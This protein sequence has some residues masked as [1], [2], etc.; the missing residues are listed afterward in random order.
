MKSKKIFISCVILTLIIV[1][2]AIVY[3]SSNI[4]KSQKILPEEKIAN[5][6]NSYEKITNIDKFDKNL[7]I[8]KVNEYNALINN[9]VTKN[10][11][12]IKEEKTNFYNNEID[13]RIETVINTG[14]EVY[15][16][17]A[18]SG[19][20]IYYIKNST[21]SAS[22]VASV[23]LTEEEI[24]EIGFELFDT[25]KGE[26]YKD[27]VFTS[28]EQYDEELWTIRFHKCYDGLV[29]SGEAVKI[30]FS[31][32][33]KQIENLVI[34]DYP[35]TNNEIEISEEEA[36]KTAKEYMKKYTSATDMKMEIMIVKP[37]YFWYKNLG[38]YKSVNFRRKAYVFTCN[39][40][41]NT[42]IYV[43]CTTGEV[44]GGNKLVGGEM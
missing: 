17:N 28:L 34:L 7:L 10:A 24:K 25:I 13:S 23:K 3:A 44:I 21:A 40:D 18:I 32:I 42:Q 9:K 26:K 19:D 36:L 14:D 16:L 31:P 4:Q 8:K 38:E 12:N 27:Y 22:F 11:L 43:D 15:C 5:I 33:R 30:S 29:N 37:N 39:N 20:L 6:G 2:S 1:L 41:A 35:Y